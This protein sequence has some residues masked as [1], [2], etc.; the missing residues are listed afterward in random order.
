M[1][2]LGLLVALGAGSGAAAVPQ[3]A[4]SAHAKA[5][6]AITA[7]VK[8]VEATP[9]LRRALTLADPPSLARHYA[10]S[11]TQQVSS[12]SLETVQQYEVYDE[13][14]ACRI[15][16]TTEAL[17]FMDGK[18]AINVS[19]NL[20]ANT[21]YLTISDRCQP[22]PDKDKFGPMFGWLKYATPKGNATVTGRPCTLYTFDLPSQQ[23]HL[24]LCIDSATGR[25]P[26]LLN[27]SIPGYVRR[28]D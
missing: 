16:V 24:A 17:P 23:T 19:T 28:H 25:L 15:I 2:S 21:S 27:I 10:G 13:D 12:S 3:H 26:L 1:V 7:A 5:A 8:E 6:A 20:H 18:Y 14:A 11:V 9:L 4:G 22:L